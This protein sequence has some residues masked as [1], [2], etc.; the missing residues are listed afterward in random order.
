[1]D[2]RENRGCRKRIKWAC[3]LIE[4]GTLRTR[5]PNI[6]V[7]VC[8][9]GM[10]AA[11]YPFRAVLP[12]FPSSSPILIHPFIDPTC[13]IPSIRMFVKMEFYL[14]QLLEPTSR[15]IFDK[16]L[17]NPFPSSLSFTR[18]RTRSFLVR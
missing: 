5:G 10:R 2:N 15:L 17:S 9:P 7:K 4:P 3:V 13:I 18:K 8:N 1:M 14:V 12:K 6:S 16:F 11:N